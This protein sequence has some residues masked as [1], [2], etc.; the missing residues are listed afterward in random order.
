MN[1]NSLVRITALWAFSEA[2]LGGILHGLKIPFAG[3]ALSFIASLCITIIAMA[4]SKT[5]VI[6]KAT[7]V[8]IA[9]KFS[10]SPYT[11]PMAYVAV[12]VQGLAGEIL[13]ARRKF[14]R[15]A[16]FI[17]SL[18]SL[19]Y[20]AFQ[21]LFTVT[22]LFGKKGWMALDEILNSIT[23]S[24]LPSST[25]YAVYLVIIYVGC[26]LTAGI[27][28][29][30]LSIR[31][32]DQIKS[33]KASVAFINDIRKIEQEKK[34]SWSAIHKERSA[35][36]MLIGIAGLILLIISYSPFIQQSYLQKKIIALLL[37]GFFIFI[38]WYYFISVLITKL[39]GRWAEKYKK[40]NNVF[41][42]QVINLLPEIKNIISYSWH[43]TKTGS[44]FHHFKKFIATAIWL[45]AY[46]EPTDTDTDRS[47]TQW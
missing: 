16:A 23:R 2:F 47:C 44:R 12:L 14:I 24:I 43:T 27:I 15:T 22:V 39:I 4:D 34:I 31:I 30:I 38:A 11:P 9:V 45:T 1:K 33:G 46:Y 28:A 7:L 6:L 25:H 5:G 19:L 21:F 32:I 42:G 35:W 8:V 41:F 18:F 37:R 40:S 26:Y 10:L 17:L 36:M 29:G 13:F 20:S 3:L